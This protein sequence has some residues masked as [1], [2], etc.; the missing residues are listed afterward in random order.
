[1]AGKRSLWREE[2]REGVPWP[3]GEEVSV[4]DALLGDALL[5]DALLGD[6]MASLSRT[7]RAADCR[8]KAV[9]MVGLAALLV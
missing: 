2:S 1:M 6:V 9:L 5:G 7:E 3:A 8:S 4:S